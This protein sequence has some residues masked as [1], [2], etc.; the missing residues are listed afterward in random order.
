MTFNEVFM[1]NRKSLK[2]PHARYE[3]AEMMPI[4]PRQNMAEESWAQTVEILLVLPSF[5]P[6]VH[7]LG[8]IMR[9]VSEG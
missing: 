9:H 3:L 8:R 1:C 2:V 6:Q 7:L 5:V 4:L